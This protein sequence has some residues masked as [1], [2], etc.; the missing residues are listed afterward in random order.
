M[1]SS[2]VVVNLSPLIVKPTGHSVYMDNIVGRIAAIDPVLLLSERMHGSW[3][4][5]HPGFRIERAPDGL[6]SDEGSRGH[7]RRLIWTQRELPK[8]FRRLGGDLLFSPIPE[9][10]IGTRIPY[11]VTLYDFI[12]M[13][14][15][16]ARAPLHIYFRRYVPPVLRRARRILSISSATASEAM[17][18]FGVDAAR[19]EVIPLAHD[20]D[21]FRPLGLPLGRYFLYIGRMDPYKNV[22]RAIRAFAA[23]PDRGE[24]EFWIA[25]PRDERYTPTLE[26]VAAEL[27]VPLRVLNYVPYDDLPGI[28]NQA[29]ALV[30]VSQAEGFGLPVLEAMA[31][32]TPVITSDRSSMPEVAGDAALLC[33]PTDTQALTSAMARIHS[34]P[35]LRAELS[36]R[37]LRRAATFSGDR[38]AAETM[39]VLRSI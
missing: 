3:E 5:R 10:P 17:Q 12:P 15:S 25:G 11:V 33:D 6:T 1:G 4:Q 35:G 2:S 13:A 18:R 29:I 31:C 9:A 30:F 28:I 7:L 19:I 36:E 22:E 24:L 26:R 20:A 34:E 27:S 14:V 23:L 39:E 38:A 21:H 37:G 16:S 32:G 8:A